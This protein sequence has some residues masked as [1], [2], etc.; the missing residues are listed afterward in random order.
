MNKFEMKGLEIEVLQ[1]VYEDIERR[2]GWEMT[3]DEN[4]KEIPYNE[5]AEVKVK[6][7]REL[8]AVLEKRL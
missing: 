8:Q 6:I 2:I 3:E 4:G 1:G 5:R 7:L